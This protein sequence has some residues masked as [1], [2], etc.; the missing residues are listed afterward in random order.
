MFQ[1]HN[2]Q[3]ILAFF[4]LFSLFNEW[5]IVLLF[6]GEL[7]LY[8]QGTREYMIWK[9]R[10]YNKLTNIILWLIENIGLTKVQLTIHRF[11]ISQSTLKLRKHFTPWQ[12]QMMGLKEGHCYL[13]L[14][15]SLRQQI[16]ENTQNWVVNGIRYNV[17]YTCIKLIW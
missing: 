17:L 4:S 13:Y 8:H 6:L 11:E 14:R 12:I 5:K 1:M 15:S 16:A 10:W 7:H 9:N 2:L 3:W